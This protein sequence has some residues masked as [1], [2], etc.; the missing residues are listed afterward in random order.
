M[1]SGHV[2]VHIDDV[3]PENMQRKDGWS[4][5]E[6][7]L[8]ITGA[9]GSSTAVFHSIFRPGSTHKKH[10][11]TRC[12]EITVYLRG[13]G[14][15]GQSEG[16]AVVRPGH[17]RLI[18]Q[19]S[20]HFFHNVTRDEDALVVGFYVG[21]KD[22]ADSGYQFCGDVTVSDLSRRRT[23]FTEGVLVHLNDVPPQT[24]NTQEGWPAGE[25]RLPLGRHN[26]SGTALYHARL[27]PGAVQQ[28]HRHDNCEEIYYVVSGHGLAGAGVD[29][30]AVRAG[31]CHYI[32]IG[33]E[34]WLANTSAT[35]PLEII[36]IYV[37]AGGVAETSF[38]HTG[39]VTEAEL[40]AS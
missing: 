1:P 28:K 40:S 24:M 34:H 31:H 39:D 29:R 9:C 38:I 25:F 23:G 4:I 10:L 14:V 20:E 5:S 19:G 26:G 12:D 22:V 8:P 13:H 33:A 6:F 37:G 2:L 16:R 32:P 18:P 27:A 36:G 7:R 21:A 11:H 30:A 15:V 17:C 3:A 35:E